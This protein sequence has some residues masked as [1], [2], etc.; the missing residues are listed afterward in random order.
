[1]LRYWNWRE[2]LNVSELVEYLKMMA[3]DNSGKGS[4]GLFTGGSV[5]PENALDICSKYW[6]HKSHQLPK[7]L[8][9]Q[10]VWA[11]W[12]V[13]AETVLG[14]PL[15]SVPTWI[16]TPPT[17]RYFP[18][19]QWELKSPAPRT[20]FSLPFVDFWAR[21]PLRH[22]GKAWPSWKVFHCHWKQRLPW[23]RGWWCLWALWW[24]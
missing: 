13:W 24:H 8:G 17:F 15:N 3:D 5:S 18:T 14:E 12:A 20:C 9:H 11:E 21:L 16:S 4:P 1:M 10:G 2:A 7:K 22:R 19:S 23:C 6:F